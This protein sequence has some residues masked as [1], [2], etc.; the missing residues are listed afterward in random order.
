MRI[1]ATLH[2]GR[3]LKTRIDLPPGAP[4]NP[5][6][7]Y[8]IGERMRDCARGAKLAPEQV[9]RAISGLRALDAQTDVKTVLRE[10]VRTPGQ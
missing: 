9:S 5:L 8:D 7:W 1:A 6:N 2:D 3:I 4:S 10:L